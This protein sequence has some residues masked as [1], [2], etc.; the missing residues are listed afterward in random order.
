MLFLLAGYETTASTISLVLYFM[1]LN[2]EIQNKLVQEI[3]ETI[4]K[5]VSQISS[6]LFYKLLKLFYIVYSFKIT[7][8]S[9]LWLDIDLL[10]F[11]KGKLSY[12][13]ASEMQY[14]DKV[15]SETLRFYP[16]AMRCL[17]LNSRPTRV[18]KICQKF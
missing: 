10:F 7:K 6:R 9:F 1:A 17:L 15:V 14:L 3:N 8:F 2:P 4:Q 5:H 12:D 13:T 18:L 11:F 16:P